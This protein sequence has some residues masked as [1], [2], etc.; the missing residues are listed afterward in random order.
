MHGFP[1]CLKLDCLMIMGPCPQ[2]V[3]TFR[4]PKACCSVLSLY[5]YPSAKCQATLFLS[6]AF[7]PET[8]AF[9]LFYFQLYF[10][11]LWQCREE[12]KVVHL[13]LGGRKKEKKISTKQQAYY[14]K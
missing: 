2:S 11:F 9:F 13:E 8:C 14:S 3:C 1:I 4:S 10:P 5:R 12:V 6:S 7:I